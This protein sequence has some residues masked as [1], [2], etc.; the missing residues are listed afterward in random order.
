V[1]RA[2]KN[3]LFSMLTAALLLG[4]AELALRLA[5]WPDPG[6]YAGDINSIW[7]LR[8]DLD[9]E[10]PFPEEGT[11][12]NVKTNALGFRGEQTPNAIACVGDSTT[13]GWGVSV[14]EAWPARL[15]EHLGQPTVNAGVPGYSSFQGLGTV[16]RLLATE[17]DTVVLA[18]LVRDAQLGARADHLSRPAPARPRLLDALTVLIHRDA[19]TAPRTAVRVPAD[20]FRENLV[21]M[22]ELLEAAGVEVRLLAFPMVDPPEEHLQVLRELGAKEAALDRQNFFDNDPIHLNAEGHDTLARLVAATWD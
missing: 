5:G 19:P 1:R 13:F 7:W 10:I 18:F 4:G 22:T 3:L 6:I 15:A 9:R 11:S 20:K 2:L 14:E 17:P 12:F 16:G 21:A 8:A